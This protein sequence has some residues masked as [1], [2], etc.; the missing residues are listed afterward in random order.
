MHQIATDSSRSNSCLGPKKNFQKVSLFEFQAGE[1]DSSLGG[2][3][4]A[5]EVFDLPTDV[6]YERTAAP[7]KTEPSVQPRVDHRPLIPLPDRPPFTAKFMNLDYR[8][9]EPEFA[10]LFD[11]T[12]RIVDVSLPLDI[13]S[14]KSRGF[15]FVE[16]EDRDSLAKATQLDG[17]TFLGRNL[18]VLVSEPRQQRPGFQRREMVPDDG[19]QRDFDNWERRGPLPPLNNNRPDNHFRER[20]EPDTRNYDDGFRSSGRPAFNDSHD[21]G[22]RS[23]RPP[24]PQDNR[25]YSNWEHRGPLP[26]LEDNHQKF[27]NRGPRKNFHHEPHVREKTDEEKK[28]DTIDNWRHADA[29][30]APMNSHFEPAK[31]AGRKKLNLAPRSK[32]LDSNSQPARSSSVFGAAKPVDTAKKLMEIEEKQAKLHQE[33]VER[34]QRKA[35]KAKEDKEEK[36][37]KKPKGKV[38]ILTKSFAALST[39]DGE[40]SPEVEET[41]AAPKKDEPTAAEKL[42]TTAASQEEL[43]ANGWNVVPTK[44]VGRK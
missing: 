24:P 17:H 3:S 18:R 19:I 27:G 40:A 14:G 31:P 42:L 41:A 1:G 36:E 44:K 13:E 2:G 30:R 37:A 34:E 26:P 22:F 25:D 15:A 29:P 23:N 5:D 7:R 32:P 9:T 39:E 35:A 10:G 12:F 33:R 11:A 28:L 8:T 21:G 20:R 4:W 6:S 43:E 38:E 16:F